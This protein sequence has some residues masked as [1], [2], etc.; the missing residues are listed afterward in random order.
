VKEGFSVDDMI[1]VILHGVIVEVYPDR[2]RGLLYADVVVEG[3]S[4]PLHV[5]CEHPHPE[6]PVDF[7]TAYVP[8]AEVWET[9]TRRRRKRK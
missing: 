6:A 8:D 7:V 4:L 1:H 2:Q 5:I 3:I 9:P